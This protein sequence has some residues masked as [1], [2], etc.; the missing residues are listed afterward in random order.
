MHQEPCFAYLALGR[1]DGRLS[2]GRRHVFSSLV[3]VRGQAGAFNRFRLVQPSHHVALPTTPQ[4]PKA[5][6]LSPRFS[7]RI[8]LAIL[9]VARSPR[10]SFTKTSS[11]ILVSRGVA[12]AY[13]PDTLR[14][15]STSTLLSLHQAT[16]EMATLTCACGIK[17]A[18]ATLSKRV[19]R[20]HGGDESMCDAPHLTEDGEFSKDRG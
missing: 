4:H 1:C 5:L 13:S 14:R 12:G 16:G 8:V 10:L 6:L 11:Q 17:R 19:E 7:L 9:A 3:E 2:K 18:V 20:D 15:A